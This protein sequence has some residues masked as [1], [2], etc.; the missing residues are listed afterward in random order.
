MWVFPTYV[1]ARLTTCIWHHVCVCIGKSVGTAEE[2]LCIYKFLWFPPDRGLCQTEWGLI[3]ITIAPQSCIFVLW[4]LRADWLNSDNSCWLRLCDA[5]TCHETVSQCM[6]VRLTYR[7]TRTLNITILSGLD[8][9]FV[10]S[11]SFSLQFLS[12]CL[13]FGK[14]TS[15]G[16][17]Q[18][19]LVRPSVHMFQAHRFTKT[20]D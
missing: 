9:N 12:I 13:I 6:V 17:S 5:K 19:V 16:M 4:I 1:S 3:C 11:L 18:K 7:C 8:S 10:F 2:D 20:L 15:F 14:M